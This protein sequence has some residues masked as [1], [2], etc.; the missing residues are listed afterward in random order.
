[1]NWLEQLVREF[2]EVQ[3]CWVQTNVRFGPTAHGGYS[4]EA[5]VL[6]YEPQERILTHVETSE[7]ADSWK[8]RKAIFQRKFDRAAPYYKEMFPVPI[9]RVERIA[10]AGWSLN[11]PKIEIPG[12]EILKVGQFAQQVMSVVAEKYSGGAAPPEKYPLLRTLY[13]AMRFLPKRG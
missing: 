13:L 1:M 6:A 7:G 9:E 5:D 2:Y 3:G 4:G 8:R 11:P 12:V 10:I